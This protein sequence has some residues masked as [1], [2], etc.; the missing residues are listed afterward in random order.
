MT[1]LVESWATQLCQK[2]CES[3]AGEE[4]L[5]YFPVLPTRSHSRYKFSP[6]NLSFIK[7]VWSVCIS[8]G[9]TFL[10]CV[11]IALGAILQSTF[12]KVI[13]HRF[14]NVNFRVSESAFEILG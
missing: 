13:G 3:Q 7:P 6:I 5:V 4:C 9:S 1:G 10:I 14:V 8:C 12:D 11:A 2:L